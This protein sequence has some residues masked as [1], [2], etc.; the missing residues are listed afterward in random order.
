MNKGTDF[1]GWGVFSNT[2]KTVF[3]LQMEVQKEYSDIL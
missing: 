2:Q 1:A 3:I